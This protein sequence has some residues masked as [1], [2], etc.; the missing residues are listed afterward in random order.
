MTANKRFRDKKGNFSSKY[1][2]LLNFS[3]EKESPKPRVIVG[4]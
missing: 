1:L 4:Y 2:A 3:V